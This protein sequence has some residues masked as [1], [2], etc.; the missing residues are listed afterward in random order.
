MPMLGNVR[1][2]DTELVRVL[3]EYVSGLYKE[4]RFLRSND[5]EAKFTLAENEELM[6]ALES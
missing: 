5:C 3:C 4:L 2:Y 6:D 1:E